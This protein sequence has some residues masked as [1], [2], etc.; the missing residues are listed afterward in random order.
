MPP[1]K[2]TSFDAGRRSL[3]TPGAAAIGRGSGPTFPR[4]LISAIDCLDARSCTTAHEPMTIAP[5]K[6]NVLENHRF[7]WQVRSINIYFY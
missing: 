5:A 1:E 4:L 2:E 7:N 6:V 3:G